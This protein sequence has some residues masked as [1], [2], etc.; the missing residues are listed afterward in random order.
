[1]YDGNGLPACF[2]LSRLTAARKGADTSDYPTGLN[3]SRTV[4][5]DR[6]PP[7]CENSPKN[8]CVLEKI[9]GDSVKLSLEASRGKL[10]AASRRR[11]G[12]PRPHRRSRGHVGFTDQLGA[13]L[14][15][16]RVGIDSLVVGLRRVPQSGKHRINSLCWWER[17]WSVSLKCPGSAAP[18]R[19]K[20]PPA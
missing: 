9:S 5:N 1:M 11:P 18:D 6:D 8:F 13:E 3:V 10:I 7:A 14:L 16:S 4:V 12:H 20:E 19:Q 15:E 17:R 2:A